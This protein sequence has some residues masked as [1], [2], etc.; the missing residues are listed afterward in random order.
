[1]PEGLWH[2]DY[3]ETVTKENEDGTK[4]EEKVEHKQNTDEAAVIVIRV[5][6]IEKEEEIQI[7]VSGKEN[8]DG[9]P[10]MK[11]ELVKRFVEE[12]QQDKVLSICNREVPNHN[13][14]Y[15]VITEYAGKAYREDFIDYIARHYPEFFEDNDDLKAIKNS[16]N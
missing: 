3:T 8:E 1:M 16:V 10:E 9:E 4:T 7:Q 15:F 11:T 2:E 5:P 13:K 14:N 12:D 6:Q